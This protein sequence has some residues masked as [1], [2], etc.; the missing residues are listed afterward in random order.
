MDSNGSK[1]PQEYAQAAENNALLADSYWRLSEW[2]RLRDLMVSCLR[3]AR[4]PRALRQA[5]PPRT[6]AA[7]EHLCLFVEQ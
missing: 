4:A 5:P 2:E 6:P 7:I 1:R 3:R